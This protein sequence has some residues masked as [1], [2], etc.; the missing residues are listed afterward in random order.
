M[1]SKQRKQAVIQRLDKMADSDRHQLLT[2]LA[3][4]EE[5]LRAQRDTSQTEYE[6]EFFE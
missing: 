5:D 1:A 3:I 4:D 6:S 2:A